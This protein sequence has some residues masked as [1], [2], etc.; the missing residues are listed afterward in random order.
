MAVGQ[1]RT[2]VVDCIEPAPLAEFW[3]AMLG[4][5]I[6]HVDE[7]WISL[8]AAAP[9]QPARRLPAGPRDQDRQEPTPPRRVGRRHRRRD[10]GRGG[11]RR[12]PARWTRRGVTRTVPGDA[13]PGRERVLPRPPPRLDRPLNAGAHASPST[14]TRR[15]R[16]SGSCSGTAAPDRPQG[17]LGQIDILHPGDE[18]GE[19]LVRHC[20]FPV[21]KILG[22]G[23][24]G[25]SWEW[26]TAGEAVRV[27]ALRRDRQAAV[28]ACGG[29][30]RGSR[31]SAT[32]A[33][34]C[35]SPSAT[36]ASTRGCAGS[37]WSA[38]C[39]QRIS[40]RQ[41][42]DPRRTRRRPAVAPQAPRA[43]GRRRHL[44]RRDRRLAGGNRR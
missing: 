18:I 10:R 3:S 4:V 27:V 29:H 5:G 33:R 26:L 35:T 11:L 8:D 15:P 31:T 20:T 19:G 41:R 36:S 23:G 16:R 12:D 6:A 1:L 24:V 9:G 32:A 14:S 43:R 38:G 25:K 28:V 2:I 42:H 39:T 13:R 40:Q 21:P 17:K 34:A 7:D 37:G 22:S 30:A 44:T